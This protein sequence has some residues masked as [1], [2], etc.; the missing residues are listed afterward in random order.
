MKRSLIA[1]L[2]K[3]KKKL[4]EVFSSVASHR[5]IVNVYF[6]IACFLLM[7]FYCGEQLETLKIPSEVFLA[8]HAVDEI[9]LYSTGISRQQCGA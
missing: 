5:D 9:H 6:C 8:E 4:S 3:K 2:N 7:L 1:H